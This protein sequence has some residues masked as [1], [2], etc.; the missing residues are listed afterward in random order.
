MARPEFLTAPQAWTRASRDSRS[1]VDR[2]C[3]LEIHEGTHP[4]MR[5]F[6][7]GLGVV[8]ALLLFVHFYLGA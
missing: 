1:A 8:A 4:V 5:W 6:L 3:P 7:G 2:A